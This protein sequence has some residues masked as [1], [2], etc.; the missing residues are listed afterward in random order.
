[1][2]LSIITQY[3]DNFCT[4]IDGGRHLTSF[5]EL[6]GGARISHTFNQLFPQ[7]LNAILPHENLPPSEIHMTIRCERVLANTS[8]FP[9]VFCSLSA[10]NAAR[11]VRFLALVAF[12]V[13]NFVCHLLTRSCVRV[14]ATPRGREPACTGLYPKMH[15]RCL[16]RSSSSSSGS[17]HRELRPPHSA[18]CPTRCPLSFWVAGGPVLLS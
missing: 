11:S 6:R 4:T 10:F 3:V 18:H 16:S 9:L 5:S 2:L 7:R 8:V 13:T 15:L 14:T 1:M 12:E 17:P